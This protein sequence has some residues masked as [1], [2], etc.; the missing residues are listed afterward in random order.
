MMQFSDNILFS[1][2]LLP[3]ILPKPGEWWYYGL[4]HGQHISFYSYKT[5]KYIAKKI[6]MNL[7][8]NG[9][10]YHLFTKNKKISNK[11]FYFLLKLQRFGLFFYVK[12][13]MK[14]LTVDDMN[15]LISKIK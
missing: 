4:N 15:F 9:R 14:S 1:T 8:S 6:D 2:Y 10:N 11:I 13:K 3:S 5:L 7:C 12:K